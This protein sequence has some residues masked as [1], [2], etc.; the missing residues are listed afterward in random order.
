MKKIVKTTLLALFCSTI[1]LVACKKEVTYSACIEAEIT[2]FKTNDSAGS[3]E[4]YTFN[5][6]T[7]FSFSQGQNIADGG[8]T[9]LDADCKQIC[10]LGGIAGFTTCEGIDFAKNAK[11]V[12]T[13]WKK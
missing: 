10:F 2:K 11:L 8:A 9:V 13:I 3:I 5:G 1:L 7:V 12:K 6:K 4:E